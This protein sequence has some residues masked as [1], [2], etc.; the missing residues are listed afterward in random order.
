M[1][2]TRIVFIVLLLLSC[3]FFPVFLSP[4]AAQANNPMV[5]QQGVGLVDEHGRALK[6][7]GV[8]VEG[9]ISWSG[10]LWGGGF[11]S[12]RQIREHLVSLVG[13]DE[14][15]RFEQAVY[16]NFITEKDI[17]QMS[18]LGFNVARILINHEILEDDARPYQYKASG[19]QLL[20]RLLAWG[21]RHQVYMVPCLISAPGGQSTW[22]IADPDK[23]LLW[24]DVKN[25]RR[26]IALWRAIAARYHDRKIIAGYDLLNEPNVFLKYKLIDLYRKIIKAVR[27][28][29]PHHMV[30]LEGT[31]S[32]TNFSIFNQ[33]LS[34]NQMY[35][36]HVYNLIARRLLPDKSADLI[37]KM[38]HLSDRHQM[39]LWASEFGANTLDW[40]RKAVALFESPESNASGWAFWPWKRVPSPHSEKDYRHLAAIRP[41]PGWLKLIDGVGKKGAAG[42][43]PREEALQAMDSFIAA[44]R[45]GNLI[46]DPAMAAVLN[47]GH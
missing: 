21:D 15:R 44:S 17:K 46:V 23:T 2:T 24:H 33:P 41:S 5:H 16:A 1:L 20:D 31:Q 4:I 45:A 18:E 9:W 13:A 43:M 8:N 25:Q 40:T 12:Q 28:V 19:W 36:Y 26:T 7:R 37:R 35:G 10:H 32:S 27:E 3:T 6:L 42:H 11:V 47:A 39:P 29:D 22:F 34:N 14:T 38:K 30:I